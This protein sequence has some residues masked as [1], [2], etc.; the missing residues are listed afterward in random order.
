MES[1]YIKLPAPL[2]KHSVRDMHTFSHRRL[3]RLAIIAT[4]LAVSA[5]AGPQWVP[6]ADWAIDPARTAVF[7]ASN[8]ATRA[9]R[10]TPGDLGAM[11]DV[12]HDLLDAG[13]YE[14]AADVFDVI[15]RGLPNWYSYRAG[16]IQ[17]L[18]RGR[19]DIDGAL[20]H[21]ARCLE[22]DP[23]HL[24]CLALQ[25]ILL[26]ENGAE[27]D[28][29]PVLLQVVDEPTVTD[30]ALRLRLGK[31]LLRNGRVV[32]GVTVLA[33]LA[34]RDELDVLDRLSF[35]RAAES[36]GALEAAEDSY[37]WVQNNHI[38]WVR[39]AAFFRDFLSRQ[40]REDEA[41]RVQREIDHELE[42][43]LPRRNMRRL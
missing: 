41:R 20:V 6:P 29:I 34:E 36:A 25:G 38:D 23:D 24:D 28:A 30:D 9:A 12:A 27:T 18:W 5:C 15:A 17:A 4:A 39:G 31:L 21:S 40:G 8:D 43:R 33:P 16:H 32:E 35:A 42:R 2:A 14:E 10:L 11:M 3:S 1:V 22:L 7:R 26:A 19:G 13:R 37:R